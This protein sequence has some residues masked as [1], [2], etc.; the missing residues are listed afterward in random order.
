[1]M[2]EA[3]VDCWLRIHANYSPN[4]NNHGMFILVPPKGGL[5]TDD[6]FVVERSALLAETLLQSTL[7]TTGA[8]SNR[9]LEQRG[10]QTGFSWSKVPVCNIE[11]GYMSNEEED[12]LLVTEAY[13]Q[14]IVDGL[15]EG[16][17][18][19]FTD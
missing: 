2:N 13:Q 14:K 17:I 18:R 7:E 4:P 12:R 11:M 5:D 1:M 15:T 10:D 3:G 19:Y 16:F 6:P 8:E 9:L